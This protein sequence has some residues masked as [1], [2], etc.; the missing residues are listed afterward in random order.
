MIPIL[1]VT[2]KRILLEQTLYITNYSTTYNTC[3]N[4]I[5]VEV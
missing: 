5:S 1:S 3:F 2:M 4:K